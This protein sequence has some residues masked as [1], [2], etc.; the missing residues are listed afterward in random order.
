[1]LVFPTSLNPGVPIVLGGALALIL[2]ALYLFSDWGRYQRPS[3]LLPL[4][5]TVWM[6]LS[7]QFSLDDYLSWRYTASFLG[8]TAIL[9]A[10]QWAISGRKQWRLNCQTLLA[11]CTLCSFFAWLPAVE[12]INKTGNLPALMGNFNNPDTFA[13]LPLVGLFLTLGLIEKASPAGTIYYLASAAFLIFTLFATG[14]RA[15]MVGLVVGGLY[16][17][18]ALHKSHPKTLA[19]TKMTV[20]IPL[21]VVIFATPILGYNFETS[22]KWSR[23]S[24]S[25]ATDSENIRM[26]LLRNGWKAVLENPVLGSGPGAFGYAY[27]SVR[28]PNHESHF[29]NIAHNDFL[30]VAAE[31]GLPGL[32]LWLG[33]TFLGFKIP[34]NLMKSGRRPTEAAGVS[35]AVLALAIF[36]LFNFIIV[37]RPAL[38]AQMWVFGLALSFP[39]SRHKVDLASPV[40]LAT[41][42][43]LAGLGLWSIYSGARATRADALYAQ[44]II[45]E[46][47]L[48]LEQAKARYSEAEELGPMN[49]KFTLRHLQLLEK[50]RL[51]FDVDNL[52]QQEQLVRAN[53][54]SSPAN[55]KLLLALA[56]V[57][58]RAKDF[59]QAEQTLSQAR[60]LARF[61]R[62]AF[63]AQIELWLKQGKLND[64]A[65]GMSEWT[66]DHPEETHQFAK[67][68]FSL[69]LTSPKDGR[70]VLKAWLAQHPDE[71]GF[72]LGE[73][74][75]EEAL[76]KNSH[77]AETEILTILSDSKPDDFCLKLRLAKSLAKTKGTQRELEYLDSTISIN[78]QEQGGCYDEFLAHW[79]KL[80]R[81]AGDLDKVKETLTN[82]IA[83][84]PG[85]TWARADLAEILRLNGKNND[86]IKVI[87]EGLINSPDDENLNLAMAKHYEQIGSYDLAL[88]YYHEVTKINPSHGEALG[89]ISELVKKF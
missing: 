16:F 50:E 61:E 49:D 89:K 15:A 1:M 11:F 10:S 18:I 33:L 73:I 57:Q 31:C 62:S 83:V 85:A 27:Q 81:E 60:N 76:A 42:V 44:A 14:C 64:A 7:S 41:G 72:R 35:S 5:L 58:E 9:L 59:Q 51:F 86:A 37:Q 43:L 55:I 71:R 66:Y 8:G 23:L 12:S 48:E 38:W 26:E 80:H 30:E 20:A 74:T 75:A 56:T 47:K 4:A 53:L 19:K 68:L 52:K 17:A 69:F 29:I 21:V 2:G 79:S 32:A 84:K 28:P 3:G 46:D 22:H 82:F 34:N 70:E 45:S 25:S 24:E 87:R 65:R 36:S 67:I 54:S 78:P 13:V 40:K 6:I 77:E 39:T 88:N 63:H